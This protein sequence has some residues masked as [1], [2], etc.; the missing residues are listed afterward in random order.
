MEHIY[1][2]YPEEEFDPS[3]VKGSS[4]G[5]NT[6]YRDDTWY[7]KNAKVE[8]SYYG[9]HTSRYDDFDYFVDTMVCYDNKVIYSGK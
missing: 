2:I 9:R 6:N 1:H 8:I 3:F 7:Y 5:E 4:S